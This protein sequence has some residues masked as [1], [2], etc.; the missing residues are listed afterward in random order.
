[1]T[2]PLRMEMVA[3]LDASQVKSGARDA[4][5]EIGRLGDSA[6]GAARDFSAASVAA[7]KAAGAQAAAA[8]SA[9]QAGHFIKQQGLQAANANRLAAHE[10]TNLSYQMN[11]IAVSLASGQ[12][13]FIVMAQQGSQ[14]SQIMG[15]RGLGQILPAIAGGIAS[16]INPTTILFAA[17][18]AGA[19]AG[20]AAFKSM[21]GE[22]HDLEKVLD[23]HADLVRRIKD[24]Y[25]EA[26]DGAISYAAAGSRAL[27]LDRVT[28]ERAERKALKR[29]FETF[30]EALGPNEVRLQGLGIAT[31]P[32]RRAREAIDDLIASAKDGD[33]AFARLQERLAE[34]A[35]TPKLSKQQQK[36]LT[37]V[38]ELTRAGV[39]AEKALQETASGLEVIGSNFEEFT[40]KAKEFRK[41]LDQLNAGDRNLGRRDVARETYEEA[42]Q[43][44]QGTRERILAERALRDRL[45]RIGDQEAA[46]LIPVPGKKPVSIDL[47]SEARELLKTQEEQLAKLRL[48]ASLIGAS[49]L[50]RQRALATLEAEIE[51][52]NAGIDAHSREADR[53]RENAAAIAEMTSELDRSQAAWESVKSTGERSI[54]TLVDKLSSGDLEGALKAITADLSKQLLTLGAA[55]PL[56]NALFNSGLP[57]IADAGGI[58][59]FF[60]SLFGGGPLATG[61]MQVQA[62]TVL[63]N[64]EPLSAFSA[65]NN[66]PSND[67]PALSLAA[68]NSNIQRGGVPSQIWSFFKGKGLKDHQ[69]AAILGHVK[70]ES[71]FNPLAVGD[72]GNAF[73]LFQHNDRR[74]NLFDAI[75]G[76]KNLGNVQ[77][78]LDFV[79]QELMTTESRVMK[80]LL[81]STDLKG[82]T[83]AFGGFERPAGFSWGNPE[84]MHNWTGRLQAAEEALTTF[85]GG[86]T[87][88]TSGLSRLDGGL[89]SA[90]SALANG[91]GS[92]ADTATAFAG[93]SENLAGSL[94]K[95]LQTVFNQSGEGGAG[96]GFGGVLSS[97]F[98]GIGSLFGFQRGGDTGPGADSDVKGLV[99]A[100][101][102]VFSAPA[103]RRIGT[104]TLDALHRGSLKGYQ[105]GG[106]VSS[107]AGSVSGRAANSNHQAA[108]PVSITIQNNAG[109]QIETQE[110]QDPGGGRSLRFVLSEQFANALDTP[111][112]AASRM[113]KSQFGL[114]KRRVKR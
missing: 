34:I 62:A 13:P 76:R 75:G 19:V 59:G 37:F 31:D 72:G 97:V 11:D 83:A 82:A 95:G 27:E 69:V 106:F 74:F 46:R 43:A 8:R 86:L 2:A 94:S 55:N 6:R 36:S 70:A 112:G 80:A 25:K 71:A 105:Y 90:V 77:G 48:E 87:N 47:G 28:Q 57:T 61:S 50:V 22:V 42:I 68:G 66:S 35:L 99:H 38:T 107:T 51:I 17:L 65:F 44:A 113:M 60:K 49:D 9:N 56:K 45:Q 5:Q 15:K 110:E 33:P 3:A 92:L 111:G 64:G 53:I 23:D 103:T 40:Q 7:G 26:E 41:A 1:M 32:Y 96:G 109:V 89:G 73:G 21:R 29:E 12:S 114:Q 79:W 78:Q 16:M 30:R 101:E 54:D 88:T 93:Q 108:A 14:V 39:S 10:A 81:G 58:G 100:N 20:Q 67:N 18:A 63:V 52:R 24:A 84:A 91:S 104:A 4:R 102:Y 85:G 98:S